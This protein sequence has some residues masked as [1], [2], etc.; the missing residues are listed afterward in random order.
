MRLAIARR[1]AALVRRINPRFETPA[2]SIAFM[3]LLA[4][5]LALS[6]SF[7]LAGRGQHAGEMF[8]YAVSIAA[9]PRA[10]G[11]PRL[12]ALHWVAGAVGIAVCVWAAAQATA[13][14]WRTLGPLTLAG[15]LLY[16]I[17]RREAGSAARRGQ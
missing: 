2:N 11:R 3:A 7:V 9:L 13:E 8:V 6:G 1:P 15:A 4:G 12:T 5:A 17:A 14:A 10:P 16:A